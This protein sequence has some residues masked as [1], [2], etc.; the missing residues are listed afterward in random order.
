MLSSAVDIIVRPT[1]CRFL[2]A[3]RLT[4]AGGEESGGATKRRGKPDGA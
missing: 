1:V 3:D 4:A 2:A